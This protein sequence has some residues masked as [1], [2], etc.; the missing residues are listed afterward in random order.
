VVPNASTLKSGI[1]SLLGGYS[2]SPPFFGILFIIHY[3][4]DTN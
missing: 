1:S 4:N 3:N 2:Q